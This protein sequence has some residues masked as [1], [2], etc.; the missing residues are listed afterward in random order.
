M[1]KHQ[2]LVC[3]SGELLACPTQRSR[4]PPVLIR[5]L[6]SAGLFLLIFNLIKLMLYI[7]RSNTIVVSFLFF[8]SCGSP[9]SFSHCLV[10]QTLQDGCVLP[11]EDITRFLSSCVCSYVL[12]VIW[13]LITVEILLVNYVNFIDCFMSASMAAIVEIPLVLASVYLET[14]EYCLAIY[15]KFILREILSLFIRYITSNY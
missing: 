9:V 13:L 8:L 14:M 15:C 2:P 12:F 11:P 4:R 7:S 10:Q 5:G 1:A 6:F 3:W